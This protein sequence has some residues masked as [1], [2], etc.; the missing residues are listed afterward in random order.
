MQ[1]IE[2]YTPI[3]DANGKFIGLNHEAILYDPEALVEPIRIIRNWSSCAEFSDP[4]VNPIVFI[5]CV[6]TIYPGQ[7]HGDAG[8]AG[9][10]SSSTKCPT[11][12]GARGR[13]SGRS[14]GNRT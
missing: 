9:R 3:R 5:E 10:G 13:T 1:T 12:T 8:D 7:G 14:T 2:I 11:C 4:K 6:Q